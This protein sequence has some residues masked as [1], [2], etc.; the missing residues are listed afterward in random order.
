MAPT[1]LCGSHCCSTRRGHPVFLMRRAWLSPTACCQGCSA[2]IC[3]PARPSQLADAER[4]LKRVRFEEALALPEEEAVIVSDTV[5]LEDMPVEEGYKG[6]RMEGTWAAGKEGWG[7]KDNGVVCRAS[8]RSEQPRRGL[9]EDRLRT[10]GV[11][12]A[13]PRL[14]VAWTVAAAAVTAGVLSLVGGGLMG[15]KPRP[16]GVLLWPG[17]ACVQWMV[18]GGPTSLWGSSRP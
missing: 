11:G 3:P 5:V 7:D 9:W 6:P 14:T 8:S 10:G 4:E 1:L 12:L 18:R 13:G 15:F 17:C 16:L 2:A